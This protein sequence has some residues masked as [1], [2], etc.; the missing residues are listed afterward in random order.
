MAFSTF[1]QLIELISI[2]RSLTN[3]QLEEEM[4]LQRVK[5]SAQCVAEHL[6]K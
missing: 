1:N 6:I 3:D 2:D 5:S 4:S